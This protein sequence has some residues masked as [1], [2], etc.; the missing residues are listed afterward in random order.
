MEMHFRGFTELVDLVGL[1]LPP[2]P[3]TPDVPDVPGCMPGGGR[4]SV[5]APAGATYGEISGK[6]RPG[7]VPPLW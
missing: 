2:V 4:N 3:N 5:P 1:Y 7:T 6:S